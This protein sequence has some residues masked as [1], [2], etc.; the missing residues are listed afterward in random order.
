LPSIHEHVPLIIVLFSG[1]KTLA[2]IKGD[3]DAYIH[4]TLIKKWDICAGNALLHAVGGRMTTLDG[5]YIDYSSNLSEKNDKGLLASLYSHDLYR[6][7]LANIAEKM[8]K[9]DK[10]QSAKVL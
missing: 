2:V 9:K 5:T 6:S 4:I 8:K 10:T 3:A 1:Y 7:K